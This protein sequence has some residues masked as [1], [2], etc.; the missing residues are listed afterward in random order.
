MSITLTLEEA[1]DFY[2]NCISFIIFWTYISVSM[3]TKFWFIILE[4]FIANFLEEI[5]YQLLKKINFLKIDVGG[6]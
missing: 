5:F 4:L 6:K 1:C 2:I 3:D